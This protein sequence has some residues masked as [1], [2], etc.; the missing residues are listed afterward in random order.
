M[1]IAF[2][3]EVENY[4]IVMPASWMLGIRDK[5]SSSDITCVEKG[6]DV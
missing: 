4:V 5:N 2:I 6:L 1:V 3:P